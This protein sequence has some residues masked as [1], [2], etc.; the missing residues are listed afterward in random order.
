MMLLKIILANAEP[1]VLGYLYDLGLSVELLF[2]KHMISNFSSLFMTEL[3]L[4]IR[5]IYFILKF[6]PSVR[7]Y[8]GM[9][10]LTSDID[11]YMMFKACLISSILKEFKSTFMAIDDP[12]DLMTTFDVVCKTYSNFEVRCRLTLATA[13]QHFLLARLLS[14]R[15]DHSAKRCQI[16]V[17]LCQQF[18]RTEK[19]IY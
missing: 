4:R 2:A 19:Q 7:R 3:C 15:N 13:D 10:N 17:G 16:R 5:D 12:S 1:E 8:P 18:Q 14:Q 11:F 6:Y 9:I